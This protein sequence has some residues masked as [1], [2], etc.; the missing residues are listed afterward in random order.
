MPRTMRVI[1][2]VVGTGPAQAW[3]REAELEVAASA[4]PFGNP[5]WDR[6]TG[7]KSRST[8]LDKWA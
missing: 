2:R 1:L 8:T 6:G 7:A 3:S 5:E 4:C